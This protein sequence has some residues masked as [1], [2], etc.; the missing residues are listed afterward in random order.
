M[1]F[2]VFNPPVPPA[3]GAKI[4]REIKLLK[5]EFGDGYTSITRDGVNHIRRSYE[6]EWP[7][8]TEAESNAIVAFLEA[9]G[10]DE[11]FWFSLGA[12]DP[13]KVTCD[14]WEETENSA[15]KFAITATFRQSFAI[16]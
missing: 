8:L 10:G 14:T 4:K 16:G 3:V 15:G 6:L 9:R 12:R 1:S 7:V 11:T 2:P 13:M 5:A